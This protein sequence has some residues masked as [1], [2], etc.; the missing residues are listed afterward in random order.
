MTGKKTLQGFATGFG[1]LLCG[2]DATT[3]SNSKKP[4]TAVTSRYD[5]NEL[6][7]CFLLLPPSQ[8]L[9]WQARCQRWSQASA[10]DGWSI[11]FPKT[12]SVSN[13]TTGFPVFPRLQALQS[14]ANLDWWHS[15]ELSATNHKVT[16]SHRTFRAH[17]L[18]PLS[19]ILCGWE[20]LK[21][22]NLFA[23]IRW[24]GEYQGELE[25]K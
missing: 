5:V 2:T 17:D 14:R 21:L 24:D 12:G 18:P 4:C 9:G 13:C 15:H 25:D 11:F 3:I 8:R 16:L 19:Q 7:S 10:E 6:L 20:D 22:T 1:V 23:R